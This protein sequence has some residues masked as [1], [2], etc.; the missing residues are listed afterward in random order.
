[1]TQPARLAFARRPRANGAMGASTTTDATTPER[2]REH[3]LV[4]G[5][6][7]VVAS[8]VMI[9]SLVGRDATPQLV[10]DPPPTVGTVRYDG[11]RCTFDGPVALDPADAARLVFENQTTSAAGLLVLRARAGGGVGTA[12]E[13]EAQTDAEPL[14]SARVD[15][16]ARAPGTWLQL[17]CRDGGGTP[18][19]GPVLR[20]VDG[21]VRADE[22]GCTY[23]GRTEF[24]PGEPI[25]IAFE[26]AT[27]VVHRV[28]VYHLDQPMSTMAFASESF[29]GV[30]R[31][32]DVGSVLTWQSGLV[33]GPVMTA[34]PTDGSELG[35]TCGID[36]Q[37]AGVTV[38]VPRDP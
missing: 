8:L 27:T 5:A 9:A 31:R 32:Y 4:A 26:N 6:A 24:E 2:R 22:L 23:D 34:M 19:P 36:G 3:A 11:H 10:A 18:V 7:V 33:L 37:H 29:A 16:P 35:I 13:P 21:T 17:V 15:L 20:A 12:G 38:L 30:P 1:V 28:D 25:T 14:G